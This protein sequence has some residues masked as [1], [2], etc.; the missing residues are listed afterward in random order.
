MHVSKICTIRRPTMAVK[1]PSS[2]A[3]N[4][5]TVDS[6]KAVLETSA[7]NE[8]TTEDQGEGSESEESEDYDE[9]YQERKARHWKQSAFAV[10]NVNI[11]WADECKN[12]NQSKVICS[13]LVC[14]C[15]GADRVGNMAVLAQTTEVYDHVQWNEETGFQSTSRRRRPKLLWVLGPYWPINLFL[16]YPLILGV[17]ALVGWNQVQHA[18][19]AIIISWSA[20]TLCLII[21]LG[22]ISCRNPGILYRHEQRPPDSADWRW[23]D[24]SRTYRPPY[25]RFDPECQVVI[26]GFDHT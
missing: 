11:T 14:G 23:N 4:D 3:D 25:A 18:H 5:S 2:A 26:E 16:T 12:L 10:G 9:D 8:A 7:N 13:A 1:E 22:M 21:S 19:L 17:S 24:Q 20:C 6:E 15:L